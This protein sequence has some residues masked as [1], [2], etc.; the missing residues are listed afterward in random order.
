M[1]NLEEELEID[2]D[3]IEYLPPKSTNKGKSN[4][5]ENK[6]SY[7]INKTKREIK[8]ESETNNILTLKNKGIKDNKERNESNKK[9][10][11]YH[12]DKNKLDN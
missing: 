10:I 5:N 11:I 3:H 12:N 9:S 8:K 2:D 7:I 1:K 4:N 6:Y